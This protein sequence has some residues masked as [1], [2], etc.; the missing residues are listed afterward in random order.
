MLCY[1]L[2]IFISNVRNFYRWQSMQSG[3]FC[4]FVVEPQ[5]E[6]FS[7]LYLLVSTIHI[8][9]HEPNEYQNTAAR[10]HDRCFSLVPATRT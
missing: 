6:Q 7:L 2:E 3:F 10:T 8:H 1:F 9:Q 4:K 5:N